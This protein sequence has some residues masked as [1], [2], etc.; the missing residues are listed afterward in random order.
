MYLILH[1]YAFHTTGAVVANS[2]L[3]TSRFW[4]YCDFK[5][6]NST[7][8]HLTLWMTADQ[9]N[10][11][12]HQVYDVFENLTNLNLDNKQEEYKR[13]ITYLWGGQQPKLRSSFVKLSASYWRLCKRG[14]QRF[15]VSLFHSTADHMYPTRAN[16]CLKFELH[17]L[18]WQETQGQHRSAHVFY[19]WLRW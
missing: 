19:Q 18:H 15:R 12:I 10:G 7:L 6:N 8:Q 1:K 17:N 4:V 2:F 16:K 14:A 5:Q 11:K 9:N 3:P 13:L